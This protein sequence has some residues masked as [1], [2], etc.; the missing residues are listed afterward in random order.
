MSSTQLWNKNLLIKNW[1]K[2]KWEIVHTVQSRLHKH[3]CKKC[4]VKERWSTWLV[5]IYLIWRKQSLQKHFAI[6]SRHRCQRISSADKRK[7]KRNLHEV[8]RNLVYCLWKVGGRKKLLVSTLAII[9]GRNLIQFGLREKTK[10]LVR[11][12]W[13][14]RFRFCHPYLSSPSLDCVFLCLDS[15]SRRLVTCS[16]KD[17]HEQH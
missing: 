9:N 7:L 15:F 2:A 8:K 16:G 4:F 14:Q 10:C 17:G 6:P 3:F 11:H 13:I 12:G 5:P 1:K